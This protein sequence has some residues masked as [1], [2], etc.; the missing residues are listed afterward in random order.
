MDLRGLSQYPISLRCN[1]ICSPRAFHVW[2]VESPVVISNYHLVDMSAS[3][4][5]AEHI[6]WS[7]EQLPHPT[8]SRTLRRCHIIISADSQYEAT[9]RRLALFRLLTFVMMPSFRL[10]Y[11][12]T[13]QVCIDMSR[14]IT[15]KKCPPA[16]VKIYEQP[17][18][19]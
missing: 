19:P 10:F 11:R 7:Y 13:S 8:S 15:W 2:L 4:V 9:R 6:A 14:N 17:P 1:G 16:S 3:H 12:V 18:H 5:N